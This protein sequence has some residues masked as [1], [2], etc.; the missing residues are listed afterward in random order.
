MPDTRKSRLAADRE[1]Q[2]LFKPGQLQSNGI[3]RF[4]V[5]LDATWI[6]QAHFTVERECQNPSAKDYQKKY[7]VKA[8]HLTLE[9]GS[10]Q[11]GD[12]YRRHALHW[13]YSAATDTY[14]CQGWKPTYG[15]SRMPVF[16]ELRAL[17]A[18][19]RVD[20]TLAELPFF[21]SFIAEEN[22]ALTAEQQQTIRTSINSV[23]TN[24]AKGWFGSAG[25]APAVWTRFAS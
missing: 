10:P 11:D 20:N 18:V 24:R 4:P 14:V 19:N 25:I 1:W 22:R 21:E 16:P 17:P 7:V 9:L 5:K 12:D 23:V 13:K 15:N 2:Q 6:W 3:G 8:W